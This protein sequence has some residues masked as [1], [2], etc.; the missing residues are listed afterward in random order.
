MAVIRDGT[1]Q[2]T[3]LSWVSTT[4]PELMWVMATSGS[5]ALR[6]SCPSSWTHQ[7][8]AA[9]GA[10]GRGLRT[11]WSDV[12]HGNGAHW[13]GGELGCQ[14]S[15]LSWAVRG[16]QSVGENA[17]APCPSPE[18]AKLTHVCKAA[19]GTLASPLLAEIVLKWEKDRGCECVCTGVHVQENQRSVPPSAPTPLSLQRFQIICF[20]QALK[21][22]GKTEAGL[23]LEANVVYMQQ[24]SNMMLFIPID[25]FILFSIYQTLWHIPKGALLYNTLHTVR[26][27]A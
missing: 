8:L 7:T 11:S 3:C 26:Y 12:G 17:F 13:A 1:Q 19:R 21:T 2:S 9:A 16:D 22:S 23:W 4:A 20:S 15:H 25:L 10:F 14:C 18:M 27:S 24:T 6:I 5:G